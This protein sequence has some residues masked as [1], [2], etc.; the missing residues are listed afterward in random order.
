VAGDN[1][2]AGGEQQRAG[3]DEDEGEERPEK[4]GQEKPCH[5]LGPSVVLGQ[6][7]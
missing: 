1:D 6:R 5:V 4:T 3:A 2:A 7:L